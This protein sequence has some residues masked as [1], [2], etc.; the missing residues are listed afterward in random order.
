[1]SDSTRLDQ[2]YRDAVR[3]C[4]P[5]E[6]T[7]H[8]VRALPFTSAP[9][10]I[11]VGKAAVAMA[12]GA[13][14]ALDEPPCR[15]IVVSPDGHPDQVGGLSHLAGDH[16]V[17]GAHSLA[18]A[19][20]I[21]A[22]VATTPHATEALVLVSGGTT[23]L[24]AAP[25][26]SISHEEMIATFELLL[27][28]GA[29][30]DLMNQIRRRLLRW[31]GGRLAA[32]LAPARIRCLAVSDVMTGDLASI[33]SGP[34]I[35]EHHAPSVPPS[36]MQRL[37]ASVRALLLGA[38]PPAPEPETARIILDNAAAVDAA[39]AHVLDAGLPMVPPPFGTLDGEAREVGVALGQHLAGIDVGAWV[40]GGET[41]V[42]LD[43]SAGRGGRCQELALAAARQIRGRPVTLLAAGTDGRDGPTDAAGA[44]VDGDSWDRMIRAGRNPDEDLRTHHAYDALSAI[45]ALVPAW[46]TGTNVNDLVI[47]VRRRG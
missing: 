29:P 20:A 13:L 46:N 9:L 16:P 28:S 19:D 5:Q 22:L 35:P 4:D 45:N 2:W 1:V 17:P 37:P 31:G 47:G 24:I 10:L 34:C 33:G 15:G 40:L 11:A 6:A 41:T 36:L 25:V 12:R 3:A 32:A 39:R 44:I 18:A 14:D 7:R 43:V 42:T 30:I 21:A 8:A 38:P 23:S 26:A 27:A